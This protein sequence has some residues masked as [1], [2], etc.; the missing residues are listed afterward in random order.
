ME[1]RFSANFEGR[2]LK[3]LSPNVAGLLCYVG[4]WISGI[5]FLVLEQKNRFI[6]F[7]ALQS[8]IVFGTL[9][10][11]GS[12]LGW[13]PGAG[14]F[15][16]WI[17]TIMGFAFWLILMVKAGSGEVF[18]MPWVGDLA[19]KL[20]IESMG[21]SAAQP[22]NKSEIPPVTGEVEP[23]SVTSAQ[24][25]RQETFRIKYY[26]FVARKGR[27][28]GSA[29]S[30]AWSVIFLV[31]F[32]FYSQY[33]AYYEPSNIDGIRWHV[34]TLITGDFNSWIPILNITLILSIIGH[35]LIIIFDKYILNQTI[36]LV[37]DILALATVVT[38]L[39]IFPFNFN[40]ITDSDAAFWAQTGA[41]ATLIV[42]SVG[43]TIGLL[44]RF[45]K[46]IVNVARSAC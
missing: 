28:V 36:H 37:L 20:T 12:I 13:I 35:I 6:R 27:M 9:T 21:Q 11:V 16:S 3:D 31:F 19:E 22:A 14:S 5:V 23:V 33:I 15:L 18:K 17:I 26:S 43:I 7:H 10:L 44:V 24:A 40:V 46:L 4:G 30:I 39:N 42:I 38:L 25:A 8:I 41:A 2:T 29:F 32:N 34:F 1:T 45:I